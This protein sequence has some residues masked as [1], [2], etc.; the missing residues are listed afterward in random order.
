MFISSQMAFVFIATELLAGCAIGVVTLAISYRGLPKLRVA[1]IGALISG[2]VFL[3]ICGVGGWAGEH[4]EFINGK[5]V[6]FASWGED[7][8]LRNFLAENGLILAAASSA[9][10][11]LLV[12][13][14][15]RRAHAQKLE[16]V[17]Q[18]HE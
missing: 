4:A 18:R 6:D 15:V 14:S 13:A 17:G 7:L 5:R 11:G 1:V 12:G 9:S 2:L 3:I 16:E 10:A 8:R